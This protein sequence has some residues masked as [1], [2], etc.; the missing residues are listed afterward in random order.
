[1]ERP[2]GSIRIAWLA[3]G[4]EAIDVVGR[5]RTRPELEAFARDVADVALLNRSLR[6][7][8]VALRHLH[9]GEFEM[10]PYPHDRTLP[11]VVVR[12]NPPPGEPRPD[13]Y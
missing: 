4:Y 2:D 7:L 5:W 12:L 9:P 3:D 11:R 1:M 8:G 6:E 10:V 13:P